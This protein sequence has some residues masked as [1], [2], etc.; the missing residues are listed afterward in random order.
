MNYAIIRHN[1]YHE[2]VHGTRSFVRN[3]SCISIHISCYYD[4]LTLAWV[5]GGLLH[6]HRSLQNHYF[7][8]H[9]IQ[10]QT[11]IPR[12]KRT[13]ITKPQDW[14]RHVTVIA[15]SN[16]DNFPLSTARVLSGIPQSFRRRWLM[17]QRLLHWQWLREWQ[18][19]QS[20]SRLLKIILE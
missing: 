19:E 4:P 6:I 2:V 18:H 11:E 7:M 12:T 3:A 17:A 8:V 1:I 10:F 16:D 20:I 13:L 15:L 14:W 5:W 9:R